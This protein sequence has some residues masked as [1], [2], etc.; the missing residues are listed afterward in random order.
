MRFKRNFKGIGFNLKRFYPGYFL[1]RAH[2]LETIFIL[3]L[4]LILLG[5]L[6]KFLSF[7]IWVGSLVV[8]VY[9]ISLIVLLRSKVR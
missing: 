2:P 5:A 8:L 4:G 1:D 7:L 9:L 3:S 6:I